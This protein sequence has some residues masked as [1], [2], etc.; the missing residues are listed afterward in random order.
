MSTLNGIE[1]A[2]LA[3]GDDAEAS[4]LGSLMLDNRQLAKVRPLGADDFTDPLYAQVFDAIGALIEAG[5]VADETTVADSLAPEGGEQGIE[6]RRLLN[7]LTQSV[8][9]SPT[10]APH[11]AGIVSRRARE[12]DAQRV[13]QRVIEELQAEPDLLTALARARSL[14]E[15]LGLRPAGSPWSG[16]ALATLGTFALDERLGPEPFVLDGLLPVDAV[17]L[18][19]VGGI[20]KSSFLLWLLAHIALA[21]PV[22]GA[23]VVRRGMVLYVSAEDRRQTIVRR[24]QAVVGEPGMRLSR[25]EQE[26]V[27]ERFIVEDVSGQSVR[28]V[29]D[30]FG[31]VSATGAVDQFVD[32][33]R[34]AGIAVVVLDPLSLLGPGERS[35]N[36]G[37]AETMRAARRISMGLNCC[38]IV[39]HHEAKAGAREGIADQYAGRGGAAFADNSRGLLQLV[40]APAL[41][42]EYSGQRWA[43][44]GHW[45]Q[46]D[47]DAGNVLTLYLH[48]LTAARRDRRPIF[49]RRAG[50]NYEA[51]YG[52]AVG[53]DEA[54]ETALDAKRQAI[55]GVVIEGLKLKPNPMVYS[56]TS[57][58][59]ECVARR[60]VGRDPARLVID[61][62]IAQGVL[63]D[64]EIPEGHPLRK[65]SR[66]THLVPASEV[67]LAL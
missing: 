35:G 6:L 29:A 65:G 3:V 7:R 24:L 50:W 67:Q 14:I 27:F 22:L 40:T 58:V 12:R 66:K 39:V 36:D 33:Y 18:V 30:T 41:A 46:E 64:F 60:I 4:V 48:K 44:P 32:T 31:A 26:R 28:F 11:Y 25:A 56:A 54:R 51:A 13:R 47:V 43:T 10:H 21:M 42:V 20:G 45:T 9:G 38:V 5:G 15:P 16:A 61:S 59:K 63:L 2:A 19:G 23:P 49:I 52:A 55:V 34:D 57:L 53:S 1:R 37:M 8:P 62:L 17:G